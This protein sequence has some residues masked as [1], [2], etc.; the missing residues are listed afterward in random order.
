MSTR[1]RTLGIWA[2]ASPKNENGEKLCRN[3]H[4]PMPADKRM[5]NCSTKCSTEWMIKTSPSIMRA[6]VFERDKGV[7]AVCRIDVFD[8][9]VWKFGGHARTRRSR[10]SGDLWQ[11]DHIVPVIEGGGETGLE[12]MRTLCTACHKLAT[13]E[14]RARMAAARKAEI[15]AKKDSIGMFSDQ[16]GISQNVESY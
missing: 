7:C 13:K 16:A 1:R 3:C 8:G 2:S 9:A 12:N 6:A 4:G 14:L 11:A 5:H 15:A 10:G